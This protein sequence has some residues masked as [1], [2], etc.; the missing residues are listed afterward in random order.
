MHGALQKRR[1]TSGAARGKWSSG[2]T[3]ILEDI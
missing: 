2:K 3:I 1:P